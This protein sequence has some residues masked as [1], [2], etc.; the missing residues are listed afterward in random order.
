MCDSQWPRP[1]LLAVLDDVNTA[2]IKDKVEELEKA[3]EYCPAC[4]VSAWKQA[5]PKT[6]YEHYDGSTTEGPLWLE[7]EYKEK[8]LEYM[9]EKRREETAQFNAPYDF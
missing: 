9:T 6:E 4:V 2:N 1:E 7:Y 3:A 5:E 8:S